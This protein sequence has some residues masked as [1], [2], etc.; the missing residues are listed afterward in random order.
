M[1]RDEKIAEAWRL[2][3]DRLTY[4]EIA[5]QLG[6]GYGA[7]AKWLN[8]EAARRW[9]AKQA[10]RPERKA[11][12]RQWE[13]DPA[14]RGDCVECGGKRGMGER[15][16]GLCRACVIARKERKRRLI[17]EGYRAGKTPVE[18]AAETGMRVGTIATEA[19]EMRREGIEVPR[20]P[21]G[22]KSHRAVREAA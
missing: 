2:R 19:Y 10:A 5:R 22:R 15:S 13:R 21:R 16:D 14:N 18:I 7:V 1:T 9:N 11:A 17:L 4:A 8:P 20:A 6:V 12:K 3:G